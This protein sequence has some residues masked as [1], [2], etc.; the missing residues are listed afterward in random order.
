MEK[1]S[2][3]QETIT[4]SAGADACSKARA[5]RGA[6]GAEENARPGR[7]ESDFEVCREAELDG[8]FGCYDCHSGVPQTGRPKRRTG[9][10]SPSQRLA[11]EGVVSAGAP[12]LGEEMGT[13]SLRPPPVFSLYLSAPTFFLHRLQPHGTRSHPS[14]HIL[15]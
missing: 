5:G 14:D 11:S 4:S 9:V 2:G 1:G 12:L 10:S 15:F 8:L 6:A 3:K 7:G 13:F